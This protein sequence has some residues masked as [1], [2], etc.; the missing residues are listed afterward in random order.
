MDETQS[1]IHSVLFTC[2]HNA[3]RSPMAEGITKSLC[4]K[5]IYVQSAGLVHDIEI[6]G[7][8]VAVCAEKG[9]ALHRHQVRNFI[10][11][12]TNGENLA[13]FDLIICLSPASYEIIKDRTKSYAVDVE[14]WDIENP[15]QPNLS[16]EES[17]ENYRR[18][19][20]Q[21]FAHLKARFPQFPQSEI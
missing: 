8:A 17:L 1:L 13:S 18:T 11:L 9:I 7:F 12:E 4:Q 21:I 10:E 3:I 14:F 20:D 6:D 2:D 16:R 15:A 19:R 5:E